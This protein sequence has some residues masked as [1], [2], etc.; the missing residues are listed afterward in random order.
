MRDDIV[1]GIILNYNDAGMTQGLLNDI[2]DFKSLDYIVVVDNC[3]QDDSYIR[4]KESECEHIH[5][6]Q[7]EYNGGYGYGNNAGIRYA[8]EK[9]NATYC[10][11]ANPDVIFEDNTVKKLYDFLKSNSE[12]AIATGL[13][14]GRRQK[15]AWKETGL[16]ADVIFNSIILNKIFKPRY[17]KDSFFDK[18][19]CEVYAVSGCFFM[20]K[21]EALFQIN[22]YDEDFFLYEEE[23]VI[24]SKMKKCGW[25]SAV[26]SGCEY[27]HNHSVTISKNIKSSRK[28][29]EIVLSSHKLYLKKY[30]NVSEKAMRFINIFYIYTIGEIM[31]YDLIK[32]S[33]KR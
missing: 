24:A 11:I 31:V 6:I 14:K 19:I 15:S 9:L 12:F 22:L 33:L 2:K 7:T 25:K 3:S 20:A 32:R 10:I 18:E 30:R 26:L 29:K 17:Y 23:K 5:V 8:K 1:V 4:L 16:L 21:T 28:R 13:C 27:I